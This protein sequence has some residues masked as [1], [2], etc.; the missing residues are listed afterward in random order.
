MALPIVKHLYRRYERDAHKRNKDFMIDI[1]YFSAIIAEDCAYCGC[2][3]AT[4]HNCEQYAIKT[5]V[6]NGIDRIDSS[7][8]YTESNTIACC[9][10]CNSAK[11][12]RDNSFGSSAWLKNRRA[13]VK[14]AGL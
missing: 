5:L 11:S 12:N 3:P 1:D 7:L 2:K 4:I 14:K 13:Y 10:A 9:R 8:G 6:Y